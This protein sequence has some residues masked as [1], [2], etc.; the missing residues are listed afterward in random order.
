MDNELTDQQKSIMLIAQEECSEVIEAVSKCFRFGIG[1]VF[2]G[3]T[4]RERVEEEIGDLL[5]MI[6][7]MSENGLIDEYNVD[8]AI[9][10]KEEKLKKWS[11]IYQ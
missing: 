8:S 2:S 11:Q 7:L 9:N 4:N 6:R 3:K 5:C 10:K 1:E